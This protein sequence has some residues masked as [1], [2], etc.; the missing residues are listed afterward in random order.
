MA[1]FQHVDD[2]VLELCVHFLPIHGLVQFAM[3]C[4][5][6]NAMATARAEALMSPETNCLH[7]RTAIAKQV[8]SLTRC[9]LLRSALRQRCLISGHKHDWPDK[10]IPF[11]FFVDSE[12]PIFVE[13]QMTVAK[14]P[15]GSPL[16]GLVD[17]D[18]KLPTKD[19][20]KSFSIALSPIAGYV[21][22]TI[23]RSCPLQLTEF[24]LPRLDEG[25]SM[26]CIRAK[27]AWNRISNEQDKRNA[28]VSFGL[29]VENG[30]LTFYRRSHCG[31]WRSSGIIC[32]NLPAKVLP[33]VFTRSFMG[34]THTRFMGVS[35][36]P[37]RVAGDD[38]GCCLEDGWLHGLW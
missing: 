13:C 19:I 26:E 31:C 21:R 29:F 6:G 35:E 18:A 14:G 5:A 37:P 4:K 12:G 3:C 2:D 11:K 33:C 17:A 25:S 38:L 34:F 23:D 1:G 15:N 27:L 30:E 36:R 24:D 20:D 8:N 32:E 22:A 7:A 16:V 10:T 28:P 9:I